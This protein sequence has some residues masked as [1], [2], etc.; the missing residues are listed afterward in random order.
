[1]TVMSKD[2]VWAKLSAICRESGT[3]GERLLAETEKIPSLDH[4]IAYVMVS[5]DESRDK[6]TTTAGHPLKREVVDIRTFI[7]SPEYMDAKGRVYPACL[8][9]LADMNSGRYTEAVLTGA[10]GSGKTTIA[11]YAQAYQLYV[12]SCYKDPHDVFGL[13]PASEI[14]IVFQSVTATTAKEVE[15]DRFKAMVETSPY[16]RH[17]FPFDKNIKSKLMFPNRIVVKP[18]SGSA[19]GAIGQNVI[20]GCIDE[21]NFMS[22]VESSKKSPDEGTYNQAVEAYNTIARRRESRFIEIGGALPGM[23]CLISSKRYRGQFTDI[24]Q[25][26]AKENPRIYV[27]DKRVW[28]IR[29]EKFGG[30][31]FQVFAGDES[32]KPYVCSEIRPAPADKALVH[33]IPMEFAPQFKADLLNSLRDIAGIS[34]TALHPFIMEPERVVSCFSQHDSVF[35]QEWVDFVD[36]L[37]TLDPQYIQYPDEP[38]YVHIDL[39]L[40]GDSCG[41][42][43]GCVT[44]FTHMNRGDYEEVLPKIHIDA[45]LEIK[46][47]RGGEIL[48]EKVRTL[49]Y[50]LTKIGITVGWVTFDSWQSVDSLQ[51][52]RGKGYT[53]GQVSMDKTPLPFTVLKQALYDQRIAAPQHPHCMEEILKLEINAQKGKI[54]H[55]P[56]GSKDCADAL[57]GVVYGI[58]R[59]R[60][61][62]VKHNIPLGAIPMSLLSRAEQRKEEQK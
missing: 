6:L 35:L 11:L 47:P 42:A 9:A 52:L 17:H 55:R 61:I 25:D 28:D 36:N 15:Y 59:R 54:D 22:I 1:M 2:E 29:P 8:D 62:W 30:E 23:L 18:V 44:G 26:E 38:R 31:T 4:K 45:I 13:D 43:V 49:V 14:E 37:L 27:Y 53:V 32:R 5:L 21:L 40:T 56:D 33:D 60:E 50:T 3:I 16:F 41:F 19:T 46:P 58:S 34:T 48:F 39:G 24:K 7:E 12:L 51:I 57:A 20:G 10:I